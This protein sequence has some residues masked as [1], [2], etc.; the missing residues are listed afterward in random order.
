MILGL[1]VA[2]VV[3]V[4]IVATAIAGYL[5]DKS[6]SAEHGESDKGHKLS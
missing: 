4:V 2:S 1:T 6:D 5:I 3:L